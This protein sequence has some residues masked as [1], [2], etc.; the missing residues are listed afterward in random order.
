MLKKNCPPA[1]CVASTTYILIRG[2]SVLSSHRQETVDIN[3][4][5][6]GA[7]TSDAVMWVAFQPNLTLTGCP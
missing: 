3:R 6:C 4:T 7:I 5:D 1:S 2:F